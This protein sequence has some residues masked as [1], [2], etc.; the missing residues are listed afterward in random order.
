MATRQKPNPT[1]RGSDTQRRESVPSHWTPTSSVPS[2]PA[3]ADTPAPPPMRGARREGS[4][5]DPPLYSISRQ[6]ERSRR[7]RGAFVEAAAG[8]GGSSGLRDTGSAAAAEDREERA[9][10]AALP[11]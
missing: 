3:P 6:A 1:P 4:R 7:R 9:A 8:R 11:R 2:R 10:E 5:R